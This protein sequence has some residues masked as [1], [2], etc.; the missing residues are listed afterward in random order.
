MSKI[1][2]NIS[3][4]FEKGLHDILD[5]LGVERADFCVGYFNL[6]GWGKVAEEVDRLP[7]GEAWEKDAHGHETPI[8][9]FCRLLVG[10]HRP[11]DELLAEA[12]APGKVIPVDGDR[13]RAWRR[14]AVASFRRQLTLGAPT[15]ADEA[16]LRMLR[17][18]LAEG[19]VA[20]KLHLAYQLH[21][22]LYLAYRPG[23]SS[24]P[25]CSIM[26]SS[27]LTFS[28]LCR[29]GELNAEFGDFHD[30]K[31]FAAWFD[32][33]WNDTRSVDITQDLLAVL[34]ESWASPDGPTPYEVYLKV[35][36]HLSREA[37]QGVSET[38]LP[39][40]FDKEL[41][42]FQKTAVKL[43]VRHLE[44]RGGAMIGDVV[45]LGKTITACA[46]AKYYED[47]L[48]ASTL[49]LCPPNLVEMWRSY[50]NRYDLKM[51]VR[52]IAK[53][54]DAA[55]ER[56]YK[57]VIIDESHN[58]RNGAGA[59][60]A[61]VK[62]FLSEQGNKVLLLT[63]T[64]YNK[65]YL[66]LA[67]QLRLFL[68]P[69]LDLGIRPESQFRADGGEQAFAVAHP[70]V[71]L[72]S[73]S[74]FEKS[75]QSDDWRDLMKLFLVRRTR[76]FIQAHYAETD[77][78]DG[79]KY[80][81]MRDGTRHYFPVRVPKTITFKTAPGDMFERLFSAQMVNWMGDLELPRYGLQRHVVSAAAATANKDERVLLDNLSRAGKRMMGF[82]RSGF[83]KRMDSSGPAFLMSLWRHAVRNEMFLHALAA[84][85]P[86]PLRAGAE[87][88]GGLEED[89]DSTGGAVL[90]VSTD[91]MDIAAAGE[92]AYASLAAEAP[93]GVR[94]IGS[95]F[96][97]PSLRRALKKDNATLLK[98]L[99]LCGEWRPEEDEKLNALHRLVAETYADEKVLVFTQYAD[100]AR[101]VAA[102]LKARGVGQVVEIDGDSPDAVREVQR[103]SPLSNGL[104]QLARAEQTRVLVTTDT[105]SEGQN[106]QDGH[107][108]VNYDLP[109]AIIRLIQRAG[110]VDRIG[111]KSPEVTC[112]S[113]FPQ[114][115]IN[116]LIHLRER[117]NE[118]INAAAE[119]I[120]SD[121]IFFEGNKQNLEDIFNEKAGI[122]DDVDDGEVDLASQAYQVWE[123]ATRDDSALAERI[124]NL[125]DVVYSTKPAREDPAGV[126]T[127]AQTRAGNDV[128]AW[129]DAR[130]ATVSQSPVR[131]L[132]A[133]A[134]SPSTPKTEPLKDHH[135]LV[136]QA[137][138]AVK[139]TPGVA[140]G[141][142]GSRMS[143][144][145]RLYELLQERLR[146][147][148]G[149]LFE[150][151]CKAAADAVYSRPLRETA[152]HLLGKMIRNHAT[153]DEILSTLLDFHESGDLC[154]P[155]EE[156]GSG[157]PA[158]ARII[159]S[160][161]FSAPATE[162]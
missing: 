102:Q 44:K 67:A 17:R 53:K 83:F 81:E 54:I 132:Q 63:A 37:R 119:T 77:P 21:A 123:S 82:C 130:G 18:Q 104:P 22:K 160:M 55:H 40:P 24:N 70:D 12:Y 103:F 9:R 47:V 65:D 59:R 31:R 72:S 159:C 76:T 143:V 49:V 108:V 89:E 127:Y 25:I 45:G 110:R 140:A 142:L 113:F 162:T 7:G 69:D 150:N 71:P 139:D 118:R 43:A 10:M 30:N 151:Q 62:D 155:A 33:R 57:L 100:T 115:G 75:V 126:V 80:L 138:A 98:M 133:L 134:C 136:A 8:K 50:A 154:A 96:F 20:V 42:D 116:N 46:V 125:A 137:L 52:S 87:L 36:F 73:L 86:L 95:R 129:L 60:Y 124:R 61:A 105:L 91:P 158:T 109:W 152:K 58:L 14:Q 11:E 90:R 128:L 120:G 3:L 13:V 97:A 93:A 148:A 51:G 15:A 39:P 161:G 111:Q 114:E 6:R 68:D 145:Y 32:E 107:I 147:D 27:N 19:R 23:D 66:D 34:D 94:W 26:G 106:L 41:F 156:G 79:R 141:V 122:L 149:T 101:Y 135:K 5:N 85:K 99:E 64:P 131:I 121:E 29:N 16:A 48:G 88:D 1:F 56:Y 78:A 74:A 112:Y 144:K 157:G 153:A 92:A 4:S 2:D 84:G 38:R 117:L 146:Q 35:M 28:G